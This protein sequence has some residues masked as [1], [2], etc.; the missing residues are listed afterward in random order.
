MGECS[1]DW[2]RAFDGYKN[3]FKPMREVFL[4]DIQKANGALKGLSQSGAGFHI[5]A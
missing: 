5:L 2:E 3:L 1:Y 4:P